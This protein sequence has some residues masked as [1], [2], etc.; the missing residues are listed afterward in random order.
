MEK[1]SFKYNSYDILLIEKDN[2]TT[3]NCL[4]CNDF[5]EYEI[6]E[7][8]KNEDYNFKDPF[9]DIK[10]IF[11]KNNVKIKKHN[12]QELELELTLIIGTVEERLVNNDFTP[13]IKGRTNNFEFGISYER[14]SDNILVQIKLL[15]DEKI[16][17]F[18]FEKE[19][20]NNIINF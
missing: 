12:N 10:S 18:G 9:N 16:H 15:N 6:T 20:S 1:I 11:E 3:I 8:F 2:K 17:L 5:E 13:E 19:Q 14:K 4:S 7:N